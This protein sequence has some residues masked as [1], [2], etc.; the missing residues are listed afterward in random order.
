M[1]SNKVENLVT[2]DG[3]AVCIFLETIPFGC[4]GAGN[5]GAASV[6]RQAVSYPLFLRKGDGG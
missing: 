3:G 2:L 4:C 1:T 6:K 5:S